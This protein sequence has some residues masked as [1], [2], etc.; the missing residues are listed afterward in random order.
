MNSSRARRSSSRTTRATGAVNETTDAVHLQQLILVGGRNILINLRKELRPHPLLYRLQYL[1]GISDR[2]LAYTD[3][4]THLHHAGRFDVHAVHRH[5]SVLDG[6]NSD[7]AGLEN[8]SR[9]QPFVNSC[10]LHSY[11]I[12]YIGSW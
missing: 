7:T 8:T 5:P 4:L 11:L 6:I 3:D 10:F 12:Y 1:E 9:P 2:R